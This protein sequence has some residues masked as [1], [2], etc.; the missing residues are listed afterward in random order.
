MHFSSY[1]PN[2]RYRQR[3][4][5]RMTRAIT[6]M[7]FFALV[8]GAGFWLGDLKSKQDMYILQEEYYLIGEERD[9]MQAEAIKIRAEAQTATVRLEQL[10]ANY[11]ELF[12]DG[13][14]KNLVELLRQQIDQGVD[15]KRLESVILSARPPQNCSPPKSKR[16]IVS[17]PVY[18]G[19]SS[20]A[21]LPKGII[22][23]SGKG[24]STKNSKGQK[25]A[26]FDTRKPIE[27]IFKIKG[28][29]IETK[30][31]ILPL[32]HSVVVGD[33]EYR[34]TIKAVDKSF[35]KITYDY[36]DYS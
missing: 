32:Y 13:P 33:K 2:D 16:F 23:I 15:D 6:L 8:F 21:I 22:V 24:Q 12:G 7:F 20:K 3:A 30:K 29:R 31:G 25:E 1:N 11:D 10:K 27:L 18:N 14:M 34:F 28:G 26:W 35:V 17:T 9:K 5:K 36:C 19:P 4:A